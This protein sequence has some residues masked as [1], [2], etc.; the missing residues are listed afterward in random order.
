M[1]EKKTGH[2]PV[3]LNESMNAL[4][5]IDGK[6]YIDA[7]FGDGGYS[8][9][10]L[11]L[12]NCS[13]IAIDQD[14]DVF[15]KAKYMMEKYGNRF[16]F[17][18]KKFS[19][20]GELLLSLKIKQVDGFVFDIGVSSM[21]IDND[22]RGFSFQKNGKLD[23][24]MSQKGSTAE[25]IINNI[26]EGELADILFQYGDESKSRK[27][28]KKIVDARKTKKILTTTELAGIVSSCFPNK[29]YKK[30]PATQ[31]FQALRM[32]LNNEVQQLIIGLNIASK[33]LSNGG[34]LCLVTFHSIED[35]IVKNFFKVVS[36][37]NYVENSDES[38]ILY[39]SNRKA[40]KPSSEEV[41]INKRSR[42]AKLRY[43][44]RNKNAHTE[45]TINQL[46]Y[47]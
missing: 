6:T 34:K 20:I 25:D 10:I 26:E 47:Y 43:G 42:S 46:G 14:P 8:E 23:M 22:V 7:T 16:K 24:R 40:I 19:E 11:M 30:H 33:Y 41:T 17:Y 29:Y 12:A 27:I 39:Q 44:T 36:S 2:V 21:Q 3:L 4:M 18:H 5:P 13:V 1:I 15:D 28:A 37:K 38:K 32:Y 31:S 45:I 9:K 35:R